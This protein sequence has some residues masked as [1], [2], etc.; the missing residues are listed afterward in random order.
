M[1]KFLRK[2]DKWILAI[3]GSMLM[4]AFLLPQALQQM[5]QGGTDR[6]VATFAHG[7]IRARERHSANSRLNFL[8]NT[9]PRVVA[10]LGVEDEDH[11]L[12]LVAEARRGGYIGGPEAGRVYFNNIARIEGIDP[13][14]AFPRLLALTGAS[15]AGALEAFAE[16]SGIDRMRLVHLQTQRVSM[17]EVLRQHYSD[18]PTVGLHAGVIS[19]DSLL[20]GVSRFPVEEDLQAFFEEHKDTPRGGGRLDFGYRVEDAVKFEWIDLAPELFTGSIELDPVEVNARWRRARELY[21]GEFSEERQ[22]VEDDMRREIT[23]RIVGDAQTVVLSSV[24]RAQRDGTT[25]DLRQLSEAIR[26]SARDRS[27]VEL[28]EIAFDQRDATWSTRTDLQAT[29]RVRNARLQSDGQAVFPEIALNV[30][31]LNPDA[32]YGVGVGDIIGPLRS[33]SG[34]LIY[35]RV[36]DVR[37]AGAPETLE[38]VRGR[39]VEDFR[40]QQAWEQLVAR[41]ERYPDQIAVRGLATVV[42]NAGGELVAGIRA[43][44]RTLLR[45]ETRTI[46]ESVFARVNDPGFAAAVMAVAAGMDPIGDVRGL[47]TEDRVVVTQLP[48]DASVV[49]GEIISVDPVTMASFRLGTRNAISVIEQRR[50]PIIFGGGPYSFERMKERLSYERLGGREDEDAEASDDAEAGEVTVDIDSVS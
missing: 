8:R 34:S 19:A 42:N 11:W 32:P 9:A 47:P 1:L 6:V 4:V 12:M 23:T 15:E 40:L 10:Q 13:E 30:S 25:L 24:S 29:P 49:I 27:G 41:S 18:T 5:G 17:P 38:S 37:P 45:P 31:E 36:T 33:T 16:L 21:T 35:A 26:D 46:D 50:Y 14:D 43:T 44:P 22:N 2:Y 7:E 20:E 48:E 39:V 28:P 3:G